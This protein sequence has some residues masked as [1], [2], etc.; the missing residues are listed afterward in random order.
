MSS[1]MTPG[2]R[3]YGLV[4]AP[5]YCETLRLARGSAYGIRTGALYREE[6]TLR[7]HIRL[8]PDGIS[9]APAQLPNA[10]T[11]APHHRSLANSSGRIPFGGKAPG[12]RAPADL[13]HVERTARC[14]GRRRN[15]SGPRSAFEFE[16]VMRKFAEK[17][18]RGGSISFAYG[19]HHDTAHLHAHLALCPRT[20]RDRYVVLPR[21]VTRI[22]FRG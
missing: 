17:F 9:T 15:Q 5:P 8:N 19:L 20:A 10:G 2:S 3:E 7:G 6:L 18:H 22:L 1:L 12:H 11:Q 4:V 16:K 21:N 13:L 14:A